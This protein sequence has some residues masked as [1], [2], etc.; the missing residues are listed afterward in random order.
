M[1]KDRLFGSVIDELKDAAHRALVHELD[2]RLGA[3]RVG[4]DIIEEGAVV[5]PEAG[6]RGRRRLRAEQRDDVPELGVVPR[7]ARQIPH[8]ANGQMALQA[9]DKHVF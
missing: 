6:P 9:I 1:D 2:A 8:R 5:V 7:E 4:A 3:P